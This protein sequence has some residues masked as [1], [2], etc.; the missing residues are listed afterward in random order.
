MRLPTRLGL[1][2]LGVISIALMAF[3]ASPPTTLVLFHCPTSCKVYI[4]GKLELSLPNGGLKQTNLPTGIKTTVLI[5]RPGKADWVHIVI[6]TKA[7]SINPLESSP[8][9]ISED[10]ADSSGSQPGSSSSGTTATAQNA[11]EPTHSKQTLPSWAR[12]QLVTPGME[13]TKRVQIKK[14]SHS[15]AEDIQF[16]ADIDISED[17]TGT[18]QYDQF[19]FNGLIDQTSEWCDDHTD[20]PEFSQ[21]WDFEVPITVVRI[22]EDLVSFTSD[23]KHCSKCKFPPGA[24]Q[25]I[26]QVRRDGEQITLELGE[27]LNT[28]FPLEVFH[29]KNN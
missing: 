14:G 16:G 7:L 3:A 23:M 18:F 26:G 11:D 19:M 25:I 20:E 1:Y 21:N 27:P 24:S 4:D 2:L 5:S 15:C 8:S 12:G 28:N 9:E 17:G 10:G 29:S 22:S 13:E 6:P